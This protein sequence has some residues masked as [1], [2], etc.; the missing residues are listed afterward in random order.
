MELKLG[1]RRML[2]TGAAGGIGAAVVRELVGE[3]AAVACA[4]AKPVDVTPGVVHSDVFDASSERSTVRMVDAAV[5]ALGGLDSVVSCTGISGPFGLPLA[6][7]SCDA[8]NE[9]MAVNVTG[10]FLLLKHTLPHLLTVNDASCVVIASDSAL[11][12]A[13]GMS[14]YCASKAAVLQ[15]VR[16]A[17]VENPTVRINAVCSSIVDTPMSRRDLDRPHGFTDARFP[18]H[19]PD[20]VAS[21][22]VFLCSPRSRA[23]NAIGLVSDFGY[24]AR[25][26]F[27]A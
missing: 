25:S 20:D 5:A 4:D 15:L 22:V 17:A 24:S 21:E 6:E 19:T 9:V 3:G 27:P 2:V 1:G 13:E 12:V 8:W 26:A 11:V 10:T 16:A 23:I 14:P 18:V 7:I